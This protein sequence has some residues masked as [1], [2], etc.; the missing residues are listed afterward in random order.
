MGKA[1]RKSKSNEDVEE[2]SDEPKPKRVKSAE[3]DKKVKSAK[4]TKAATKAKKQTKEETNAVNQVKE[5]KKS[6]SAEAEAK[7]KNLKKRKKNK[8]K[9]KLK[10]KKL[11]EKAAQAEG[12]VE[13]EDQPP[14]AVAQMDTEAENTE[15]ADSGKQEGA[16]DEDDISKN[17]AG[18]FVPN[19]IIRALRH[20]NFA[21]PTEVQRLSLPAAISARR[22]ML[23]AAETGSGKTLAYGIPVVSQVLRTLEKF[24]DPRSCGLLACVITPTRELAV[25]VKRH[26]EA[27]AAFSPVRVALVVGGLDEHKQRRVLNAGPQ[28]VVATPGRFWALMEDGENELLEAA[29]STLRC[30]VVDEADR[31]IEEGHF[32]ELDRILAHFNSDEKARAERQNFVCSAT[33]TFDPTSRKA[34]C[35]KLAELCDRIGLRKNFKTVNLTPAGITATRVTECVAKCV[36]DDKDLFAIS[37]LF[38]H[39]GRTLVFVNSK[40]SLRRLVTLLQLVFAHRPRR[41]LRLAANMEQKA[42]LRSVES[43]TSLSDAI[44]VATDVAARGLDVPNVDYVIHYHVPAS[45]EVCFNLFFS[46]FR[47]V[48]F[49]LFYYRESFVKVLLDF[50]FPNGRNCGLYFDI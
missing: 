46:S 27:A 49:Y 39:V 36:A 2:E 44:L 6:T 9:K 10:L 48:L 33:L 26:L 19:S 38:A 5:S 18:L 15:Q 3:G 28:V 14:D 11:A 20:G 50:V 21:H 47:H 16:E 45:A 4:K 7:F 25:Q 22:D 34:R 35:S 31:L 12:S 8:R 17:W 29:R 24:E 37:L 32:D 30:L 42:R 40:S 1:K 41:I 43:F 13:K 23:I